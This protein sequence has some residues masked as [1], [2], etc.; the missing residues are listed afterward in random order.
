M[1]SKQLSAAQHAYASLTD[2]GVEIQVV[3]LI[4]KLLMSR[5][6]TSTLGISTQTRF[7]NRG[8]PQGGVLSPLLWKIAVNK[9]FCYMEGGGCKVV[10]YADDVA[11]IFSGKFP[12][13]LCDLMT[14]K[15]KIL[16]DWT[17][18]RGLGEKPLE[19]GTGAVYKQ[20]QDSSTKPSNI[21]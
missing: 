21:K 8:T 18:E 14:A 19:N 12:Q 4:H 20:I 2:L 3:E 9:L 10:A 13:T 17:T 11:I 16:S 15:L 6:V 1:D 5:M 7:V